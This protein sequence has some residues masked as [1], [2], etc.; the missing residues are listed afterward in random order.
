MNRFF[1]LTICLVAVTAFAG[2][3]KHDSTPPDS[4]GHDHADD[5][6]GH[7]HSDDESESGGGHDDHGTPIALGSSTIGGWTVRASR[8]EGEFR[9]GGEAAIDVWVTGGSDKI[10]AVRFWIGVEDG[11][12]SIKARADIEDPAEPDRWH[13]HAEIPSPLLAGSKLWVELELEGKGKLSGSFD[14]RM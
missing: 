1:V 11:A 8:E 6:E 5:L 10:V 13:T 2:C 7:A 4:D 3:K 14:L 9:A 12:G